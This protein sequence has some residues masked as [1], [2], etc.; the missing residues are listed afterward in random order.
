MLNRTTRN[1]LMAIAGVSAGAM[2]AVV[3]PTATYATPVHQAVP[4]VPPDPGQ[5]PV[6][7]PNTTVHCS[8]STQAPEK[9]GFVEWP[10]TPSQDP[11]CLL[12]T[13]DSN[14]AVGKLQDALNK[15]YNDTLT[16]DGQYGPATRQ[17]V[18]DFQNFKKIPADGIYGPQSF[19]AM[20]FPEYESGKGG[21][22]FTGH[23]G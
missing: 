5:K 17:A 1:T 21:P 6:A 13:G 15:C 16:V 12:A 10:S 22:V 3:G 8:T 18:I 23:C 19:G 2:V 7:N 11:N 4:A 20:L 14:L 9:D